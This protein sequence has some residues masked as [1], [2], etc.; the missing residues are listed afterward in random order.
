VILKLKVD[1]LNTQKTGL[2]VK[3]TKCVKNH[4]I[5]TKCVKKTPKH[6]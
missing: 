6:V 2:L 1:F 5:L 3:V 4:Q